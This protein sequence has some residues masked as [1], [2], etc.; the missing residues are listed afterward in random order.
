MSHVLYKVT[1]F[2]ENFV[3]RTRR[4]G[5]NTPPVAI[6]YK[7]KGPGRRFAALYFNMTAQG[8]CSLNFR[9]GREVKIFKVSNIVSHILYRLYIRLHNQV[10]QNQVTFFTLHG[11]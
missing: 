10:Y 9:V 5:G 1:H 7:L 3:P 4:F 8:Q 11:F 2:V 6:Q